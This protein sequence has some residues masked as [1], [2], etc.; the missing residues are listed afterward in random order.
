MSGVKRHFQL[1][2][3]AAAGHMKMP[4]AYATAIVDNVIEQCNRAM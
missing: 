3:T 4:S 1:D 2:F